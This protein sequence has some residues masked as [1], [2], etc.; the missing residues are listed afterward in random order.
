[1]Q[2]DAFGIPDLVPVVIEHRRGT[3]KAIGAPN[4]HAAMSADLA[5]LM[6]E[7]ARLLLT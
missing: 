5:R 3:G 6:S 7:G 4:S 1:M 2:R